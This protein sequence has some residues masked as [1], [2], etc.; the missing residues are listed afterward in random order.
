MDK[1]ALS[2]ML[3][4]LA[5]QHMPS[6]LDMLPGIQA[7]LK[8]T[9]SMT[10]L[11]QRRPA[12][13]IASL[14]V[15]LL[16]VVTTVYAAQLLI[17]DPGL[18]ETMVTPLNLSQT[19]G[20][21]TVT[22]DWAYADAN[23]IKLAYT[24]TSPSKEIKDETLTYVTLTD[25]ETPRD[26][27][28]FIGY[29]SLI[30]IQETA[31]HV[32]HAE[33]SFFGD[34]KNP[35]PTLNL[36]LQVMGNYRFDFTVPFNPGLRIEKQHDVLVAGLNANLE[37]AIITPSMTRANVCYDTPDDEKWIANIEL[38]YDGQPVATEP[39]ASYKGS[40]AGANNGPDERWCTEKSFLTAYDTLPD[41]MTFTITSLQT[42]TQYSEEDMQRASEVFAKYGIKTEVVPGSYEL[43]S[44]YTLNWLSPIP[45]YVEYRKIWQEAEAAMGDGV[46]WQSIDGPWILTIPL[47]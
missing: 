28:K 45:G 14:I 2:Q 19:K 22:L 29:A 17:R 24:V 6:D 13:L 44:S 16:V 4:S 7:R 33:A 47:P 41:E 23:R 26:I 3:D 43:G 8:K 36:R 10:P 12:R 35:A 39:E 18:H 27:H 46:R 32:Y 40:G 37:W 21:V 20:D 5:A 38:A 31:S 30:D 1:K 11:M 42:P 15:A 9:R 34:L 25:R